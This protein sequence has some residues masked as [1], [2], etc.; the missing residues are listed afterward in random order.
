MAGFNKNALLN[1]NLVFAALAGG[2]LIALTVVGIALLPYFQDDKQLVTIRNALVLGGSL[3]ADD[4][5]KLPPVPPDDEYIEFVGDLRHIELGL[6]SD[7][8][9]NGP[10][11]IS[12]ALIAHLDF[13]GR[14]PGGRIAQDTETTYELIKSTGRGYCADYTQVFLALAASVNIP[15]REWGMSFGDYSGDGHAF[16]EIYSHEVR[17]WIFLD[18]YYGFHVT[19]EDNRPLSYIELRRALLDG[20]ADEIQIIE[21][22]DE[23]K[24]KSHHSAKQYYADGAMRAFLWK[25]PLA[26]DTTFR[27][28][29]QHISDYSLALGHLIAIALG[30]HPE[31]YT[32]ASDRNAAAI[33]ALKALRVKVLAVPI[34]GA[35][36][37]ALMVI[38]VCCYLRYR[39]PGREAA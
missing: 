19:G 24:F 23:F 11:E 34:L 36:L 21:L 31:I 33:D 5:N 22:V 38:W 25:P 16:V 9:A 30:E 3:S 28:F 13:P 32:L 29:H 18:P 7:M 6:A 15:A 17:Q 26:F 2:L 8:F 14:G 27:G 39:S 20:R 4:V 35:L 10:V 12:K 1:S 37:G